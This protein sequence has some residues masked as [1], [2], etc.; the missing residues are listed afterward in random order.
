MYWRARA[1]NSTTTGA[2]SAVSHFRVLRPLPAAP[3]PL[4]PDE[5]AADQDTLPAFAWA[6]VRHVDLYRL[7]VASDGGFA[8]KL[9]EVTTT[10]T[11]TSAG[12][13]PLSAGCFWRVRGEN[14]AGAGPWSVVRSFTVM[15]GL[16]VYDDPSAD[17][18]RILSLFPHP[19]RD[20]L[21]ARVTVP[22]G[23]AL[24]IF[25]FD[26]L[27]REVVR[28]DH[29]AAGGVTDVPVRMD[30]LRNGWYLLRAL[31]GA[32]TAERLFLLLR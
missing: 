5:G 29:P 6:A 7:Q 23:S 21:T 12:P 3:L 8:A 4:A 25:V 17:D 18:F 31:S 27:G 22:A 32:R 9:A 24:A 11:A 30:G 14:E 28:L 1:V 20:G 15:T 2:W 19:V 13:L 26:L 10:D 16:G